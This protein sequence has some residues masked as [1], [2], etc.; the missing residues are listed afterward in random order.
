MKDRHDLYILGLLK[1]VFFSGY[2][3][4]EEFSH[5][6]IFVWL[7]PLALEGKPFFMRLILDMEH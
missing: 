1:A 3:S 6:P 4:N 7:N 2:L 5:S